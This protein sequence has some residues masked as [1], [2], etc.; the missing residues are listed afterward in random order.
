MNKKKIKSSIQKAAFKY[1]L[2]KKEKHTKLDKIEYTQLKLQPYL[3][4]KSITNKQKELLYVLRSKCHG[5]KI[6]FKKLYRNDLK[7]VLGCI[8]NEDQF[9][10]FMQCKPL[11]DK[12]NISNSSQYNQMFGSLHQQ[13]QLIQESLKLIK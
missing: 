10:V 7:C 8:K 3:S 1:F 2:Q 4:T 9:H 13:V 12:L 6:N 11:M 5:S